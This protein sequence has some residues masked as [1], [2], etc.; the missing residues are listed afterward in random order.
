MD[1]LSF[2]SND[3]VNAVILGREFAVEMEK[4]FAKDLAESNPIQWKQWK[5]RGISDRIREWVAHLFLRWL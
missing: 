5:E 2:L 1:Y 3:E 4:V